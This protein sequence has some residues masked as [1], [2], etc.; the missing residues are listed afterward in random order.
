[1]VVDRRVGSPVRISLFWPMLAAAPGLSVRRGVRI[2]GQPFA[3]GTTF[4]AGGQMP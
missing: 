2:G 3:V 4:V 1:V